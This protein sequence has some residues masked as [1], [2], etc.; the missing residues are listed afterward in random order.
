MS[1][2]EIAVVTN[3]SKAIAA[4]SPSLELLAALL[5]SKE[6]FDAMD[7]QR[8]PAVKMT[9]GGFQLAEDK[10]VIQEIEAVIIHAK[11]TNVYYAKPYNPNEIVPPDCY[12][13]DGAKPDAS[14]E[15]PQH[16]TCKGC[17]KAEFGTNSMKSGK[18][19][20]NL[21]PLY[22]LLSDK[23]IVPRELTITPSSLKAVNQYLMD[24][25]EQGFSYRKVKTKISAYKKNPK[26]TYM[27][28]RF[29]NTAKLND[30]QVLDA[31]K[32]KEVWL[33]VMDHQLSDALYVD[34][35]QVHGAED[36]PF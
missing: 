10:P 26:D 28:L 19:C 32:I 35:A 33:P 23:A 16:A 9:S 29:A 13:L 1:K 2:K 4:S 30:Q 24:L 14:I 22:L 11:K 12:S 27:S 34:S 17:P 36:A 20:R 5:E 31:A 21:K 25:T 6:N 18:A 3:E 7:S 8:L 15:K